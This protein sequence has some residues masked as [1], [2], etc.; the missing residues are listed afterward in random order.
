M[1][2]SFASRTSRAVRCPSKVEISSRN[3]PIKYPSDDQTQHGWFN[4]SFWP[5]WFSSDNVFPSA[6]HLPY[7]RHH[8]D[9]VSLSEHYARVPYLFFLSTPYYR[10]VGRQRA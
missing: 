7:L 3:K 2:R 10:F 9:T 1:G 5:V 6:D 4:R 8:F